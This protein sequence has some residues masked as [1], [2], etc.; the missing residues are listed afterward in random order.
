MGVAGKSSEP[1]L[2]LSDAAVL[3]GHLRAPAG[4]RRHSMVFIDINGIQITGVQSQMCITGQLLLL[5]ILGQDR[6]R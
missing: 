3:S 6:Q 4:S 1:S 2:G 5:G